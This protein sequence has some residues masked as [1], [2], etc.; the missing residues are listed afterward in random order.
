MKHI[1]V[2]LHSTRD[3]FEEGKHPRSHGQFTTKGGG[4][5][6]SSKKTTTPAKSSPGPKASTP[7]KSTKP[8]APANVAE[9]HKK[10]EEVAKSMVAEAKRDPFLGKHA[11]YGSD[12]GGD[13]LKRKKPQGSGEIKICAN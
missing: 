1:H 10:H 5:T 8:A 9:L 3:A 6:G 11:S 4:S 13:L 2:H 12:Y 7:T